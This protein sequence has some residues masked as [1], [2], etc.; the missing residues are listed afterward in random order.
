MVWT[1]VGPL[2]APLAVAAPTVLTQPT[3]DPTTQ[4]LA[5]Y[6][7]EEERQAADL[8][9]IGYFNEVALA[10]FYEGLSVA[11]SKTCDIVVHGDSISEGYYA[12]VVT[13]RWAAKLVAA[14]QLLYNPKSIK[15]GEGYVKWLQGGTA[16][17]GNGVAAL[18][19]R[20]TF[21]GFTPALNG[22][23]L[24]VAGFSMTSTG[25]STTLTFFGD[26]FIWVYTQGSGA[27]G[28]KIMIDGV[29]SNLDT[30]NS[31]LAG[32]RQWLSPQLTRGNH[33]VVI[34]PQNFGATANIAV[35]FEGIMVLDGDAA[36]GVRYWDDAHFGYTTSTGSAVNFQSGFDLIAPDLVIVA[37]GTNDM[38][39]AN[40]AAAMKTNLQT[41]ITQ[42]RAAAP[43]AAIALMFP[44]KFAGSGADSYTQP[45][46]RAVQMIAISNGCAFFDQW[47]LM[48][49][50]PGTVT[51]TWADGVHPG[52]GGHATIMRWV[53]KK[54]L[55]NTESPPQPYPVE[56]Q[57]F[58]QMGAVAV[59]VGTSTWVVRRA[60]VWENGDLTLATSGSSTT[61]CDVNKNGVTIYTTQANRPSL[62]SG[63]THQASL[64]PDIT[65]FADGDIIT[66]D[67]DAAGTGASGL[68]Y[69]PRLRPA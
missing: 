15:G 9:D 4:R 26:R 58:T 53:L 65:T 54:L 32:G 29:Q 37:L 55:G 10:K 25:H 27:G 33:T 45:V 13:N 12:S 41:T 51:D 69:I 22:F 34:S 35:F 2:K 21:A 31:T 8:I 43:N 17:N 36:A 28:A 38:V 3:I 5:W 11:G 66:V 49:T 60:C 44:Y 7:G 23:G 40:T 57:P 24:G 30:N 19:Q 1:L 63:Q 39:G 67:V 16:A 64:K 68:T 62:T 14:L 61:T 56:S 59:Q 52:D 47:Q 20:L 6:D 46:R 48:P 42:I 50:P 18:T